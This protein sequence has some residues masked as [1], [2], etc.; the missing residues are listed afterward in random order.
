MTSASSS[1]S[2]GVKLI[3]AQKIVKLF[4]FPS[5]LGFNACFKVSKQYNE[6]RYGKLRCFF[7]ILS[8]KFPVQFFFRDNN[9]LEDVEYC[10]Q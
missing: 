8:I 7:S 5:I 3:F 6:K 2:A 1:S 9:E 10:S 4:I